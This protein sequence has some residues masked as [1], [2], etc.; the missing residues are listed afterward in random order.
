CFNSIFAV[1]AC[2]IDSNSPA[3]RATTNPATLQ[4]TRS[5][6]ESNVDN[7]LRSQKKGQ[8]A[9]FNDHILTVPIL[10]AAKKECL[11]YQFFDIKTCMEKFSPKALQRPHTSIEE[12]LSVI[13]SYINKWLQS[14]LLWDLKADHLYG[15]LG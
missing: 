10:R 14:Q 2:L 15:K 4:I 9:G 5:M 7:H 3:N 1:Q 6:F 8:C 13:L 11:W 12:E